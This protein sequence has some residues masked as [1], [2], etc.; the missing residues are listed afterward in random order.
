MTL[1]S[2]AFGLLLAIGTILLTVSADDQWTVAEGN[3]SLIVA[4]GCFWCV[5]QAFEQY[6]PGRFSTHL[7]RLYGP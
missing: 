6:A 1:G 2:F 7:G 5:E 4:I 3:E